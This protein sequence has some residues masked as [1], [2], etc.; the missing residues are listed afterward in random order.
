M[1][2]IEFV[3]EAPQS[4]RQNK[5]RPR[6]VTSCDHCRVKKIK[7]VQQPSTGK[8][9]ACLAAHL[10]CLY[11]DREQYFAERTRMLSGTTSAL[12]DA[13]SSDH[14]AGQLSAINASSSS[15]VSTPSRSSRSSASPSSTPDRSSS[16][17]Y[18]PHTGMPSVGFSGQLQGWTDDSSTQA[19]PLG[20]EDPLQPS[21]WFRRQS[22][23]IHSGSHT[24]TPYAPLPPAASPLS[25]L[26]DPSEPSQPHPKLMMDFIH[27]FFDKLGSTYTFL[28]SEAICE[29]FL[30]HKLS[31]LLANCLA[32]SA[33][34]YSALPEIQQ[35]GPANAADV[36]CQMAKGLIPPNGA[37][38]SLDA[39]HA[40]MLLAWAEYRRGRLVVFSAYARTAIRFAS[41]LGITQELLPQLTQVLDQRNTRILQ[42]TLQGIQL[43][44]CTVSTADL[45]D[46]TPSPSASMSTG[47][48]MQWGHV[49]MRC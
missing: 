38:A 34:R 16:P 33:A 23:E 39:V 3:I 8:C 20:W 1:S 15:C 24:S 49:G 29:Q 25:G 22:P 17:T 2:D 44:A 41:Q 14:T 40:L 21:S 30:H 5:K 42:A 35:V 28:S 48:A 46:Q 31:P 13:S 36:Y 6:L 11:R 9:E 10:P 43:L 7:C 32:A 27:V 37:P 18:Y 12:R 19:V 47:H 4:T 45:R 26:F